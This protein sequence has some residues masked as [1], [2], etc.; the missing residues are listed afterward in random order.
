MPK[1]IALTVLGALTL[2]TFVNIIEAA[3]D[4]Y[5]NSFSDE[6]V[7]M[8]T[9]AEE[10]EHDGVW[11]TH[12]A[13]TP[14]VITNDGELMI[15]ESFKMSP[16]GLLSV[17]VGDADIR[18]ETHAADEVDI[19]IFLDG[20][21]MEKA[22]EY[23]ENQNF[24]VEKEGATVYVRTSPKRR[25]FNW[26]NQGGA[27]IT[28]SV[29]LPDRFDTELKTSDGNIMMSSIEGRVVLHTSDGDI[30][31]K[32]LKGPAITLRTSDGDITTEALEAEQISVTTS[33]GD[34]RLESIDADDIAIRTSD[35]DIN[36]NDIRG[37]SSI[38]TSDGDI[39]IASASG[40]EL[41]IRTSDGD[42]VADNL[43]ADHSQV[44][45]SDGSIALRNVAGALTAKTSS[46]N[47]DV[48]LQGPAHDVSLRT[49]D[50]DIYIRVPSDYAAEVYMKG[51]N[52]RIT[53]GL[54]FDGSLEKNEADGR[55]NGGGASLEARTSDGEV[56]LRKD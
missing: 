16:G 56:V 45:T 22:R 33:D 26:N 55:V 35:G 5:G 27:R 54:D 29:A 19:Q 37:R 11:V 32:A 7:A 44:Q 12:S 50:G 48:S 36:A 34:I 38:S 21:N 25:N 51:E 43:T 28:L 1:K 17:S 39:R 9:Q 14:G 24:E 53:S 49:G 52:V 10:Q 2:L 6:H 13:T 23:F 18:V 46:G 42:I 40:S 30:T 3:V 41:A 4:K 8:H 15:D 20:R 47:L 31:T